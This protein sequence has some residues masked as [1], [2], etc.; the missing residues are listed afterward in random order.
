MAKHPKLA[1][2]IVDKQAAVFAPNPAPRTALK[3]PLKGG[4]TNTENLRSNIS[5]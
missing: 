4:A 2:Q 1:S 3:A 5:S